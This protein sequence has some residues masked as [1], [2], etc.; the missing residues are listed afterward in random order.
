MDDAVGQH[1]HAG[2]PVRRHVG[3]RA[4]QRCEQP[5]ALVA[6]GLRHVDEARLDLG[7]GAETALQLG[8]HP[9]GDRRPVAERLRARA[10]DHDGDDVLDRLA[11]LLDQ[12][13]IGERQQHQGE[14]EDAQ[15][16]HRPAGEKATK[17]RIAVRPAR[18]KRTGT[19]TSG[20]RLRL[21]MRM[22]LCCG[23]AVAA[24]C[25]GGRRERTAYAAF[26]RPL[27]CRIRDPCQ[28]GVEI[29]QNVLVLETHQTE[30]QAFDFLRFLA[31]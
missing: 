11:L 5:R 29:R 1:H 28:D 7:E 6:A 2:E 8:P 13:G 9:V 19:G 16:R 26:P 3:E 27:E 12:R 10:I 31:S 22:S 25:R 20:A 23:S 21:S 17:A 30:A 18:P 14:D 24:A 4:G 15:Q